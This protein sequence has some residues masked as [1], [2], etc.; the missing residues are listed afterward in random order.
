MSP[1]REAVWL[2]FALILVA[3][4]WGSFINQWVDRTPRRRGTGGQTGEQSGAVKPRATL[5]RPVRSIC[6]NCGAGIPWYDNIPVLSFLL[7]RGACRRCG[8]AI[9]LRTLLMEAAM[10]SA[11]AGWVWLRTAQ[12]AVPWESLWREVPWESLW[13]EVPWVSPWREAPWESPWRAALEFLLISW[14]LLVCALLLERRRLG[15]LIP[16][17]GFGLAL[18]W[19]LLSPR[20]QS[21]AL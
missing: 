19:V 6:F 8:A 4:V 9:G 11:I 12:G 21:L 7:L 17:L 18:A 13:R 15:A 16:L 14:L 1:I 10:P 2:G 3:W 5:F 20:L